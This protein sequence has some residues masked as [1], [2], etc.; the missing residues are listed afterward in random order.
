MEGSHEASHEPFSSQEGT[1]ERAGHLYG[2]F[3]KTCTGPGGGN[4]MDT[5]N[6]V[7][8]VTNVKKK[9]ALAQKKI[10]TYVTHVTNV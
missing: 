4:A 1:A 9:I 2:L 5:C 8:D 3:G 7:T 10:S 6:I